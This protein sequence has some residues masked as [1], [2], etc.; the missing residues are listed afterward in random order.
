MFNIL[1]LIGKYPNYGGTEKVTTVLGNEFVKRGHKV[2]I[3]SFEQPHPELKEEELDNSIELLAL[4]YPVYKRK[5]IHLLKEFIQNKKIDFIIN[6]WCLPFHV[7]YLVNKARKRQKCKL[8]SALHGVPDQNKR[9]LKV[10]HLKNNSNHVIKRFAYSQA[11]KALVYLTALNLKYVYNQS[12]QYV[13]LSQ[14]FISTFLE[15]SG[16][17]E[18]SRLRAISNSITIEAPDNYNAIAKLK[19]NKVLYVGR[20]DYTNKRVHRVVEAWE[21][22]AL[23]YPDWALVLVGDGPERKVLENY[24]KSNNIDRVQ[25]VG[26]K[27]EPPIEFYKQASILLLTSDLEGFGLV[28][29]EG[30][31]Y[32]V[33]PIVYGSYSAIYDIIEH[34][35]SGFITPSPYQEANTI[36]CLEQ[37]ICN[38]QLRTKMSEEAHIRAQRFSVETIIQEWQSMFG[39][40]TDRKT[41]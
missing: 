9:L 15:L 34:G 5:N 7:T 11:H 22:I 25:F 21:K 20:M 29:I 38:Q 14:S 1:F 26:F 10:E 18:D 33:V 41:S 6:Q 37:L 31:T 13:I 3:A 17:K 32:G 8:I 4:S 39:E 35:I 19:E 24:T 2:S 30:M 12:D 16:I 27:K 40:L 23:K 36:R 28:V